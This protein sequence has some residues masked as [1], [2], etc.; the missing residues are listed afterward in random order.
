MKVDSISFT[1]GS[2]DYSYQNCEVLIIRKS[3]SIV[4]DGGHSAIFDTHNIHE[5]KMF[6]TREESEC[7]T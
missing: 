3:V 6:F 7:R 4:E 1:Y 5:L 2:K